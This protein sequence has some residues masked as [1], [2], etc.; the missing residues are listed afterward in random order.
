M[1]QSPMNVGE[2]LADNESTMAAASEETLTD[3]ADR[4]TRAVQ[5]SPSTGDGM[6]SGQLLLEQPNEGSV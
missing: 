6:L 4:L 1:A 3:N 2:P 5:P